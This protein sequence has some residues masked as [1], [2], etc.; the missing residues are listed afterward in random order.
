MPPSVRPTCHRKMSRKRAIQ[1]AHHD[2]AIPGWTYSNF[3]DFVPFSLPKQ[4]M[5]QAN[6]FFQLVAATT[7]ANPWADVLLA[8]VAKEGSI[9][10]PLR[11]F[12]FTISSLQ[13][14]VWPQ[15]NGRTPWYLWHQI[16]F[17]NR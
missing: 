15:N 7:L 11:F 17:L 5:V 12:L 6:V 4:H 16:Y 10:A 14:Q 2:H 13:V 9:S 8:K 1:A 3:R